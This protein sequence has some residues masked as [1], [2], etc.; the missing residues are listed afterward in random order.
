VHLVLREK[1]S[2]ELARD[3]GLAPNSTGI[4]VSGS[5]ELKVAPESETKIWVTLNHGVAK[6]AIPAGD[7]QFKTH[8]NVDKKAWADNRVIKLKDAERGFP[9]K[10]GLA[11]LKWRLTTKD[12]TLIPISSMCSP[13]QQYKKSCLLSLHSA[14][15]F[16]LLFFAGGL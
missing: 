15:L 8:P 12:E 5:L 10:Q 13:N 7:I 4:N 14:Y 3:G 1:L 6:G 9:T 16:F 2:A 11:V